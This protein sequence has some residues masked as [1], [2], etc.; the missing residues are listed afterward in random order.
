MA[1]IPSLRAL[2]RWFWFST[3]TLLVMLLNSS[4]SFFRAWTSWSF[5]FSVSFWLMFSSMRAFFSTIS[6]PYRYFLNLAHKGIWYISYRWIC[7]KSFQIRYRR[8]FVQPLS[9]ILV[10]HIYF[11]YMWYNIHGSLRSPVN[12]KK[13]FQEINSL[14][15]LSISCQRESNSWPQHYQCC[16]LPSELWQRVSATLYTILYA[17]TNCQY[18]FSKI[19]YF[20]YTIR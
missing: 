20:F 13:D 17:A 16:A 8:T 2:C 5:L 3:F 12:E 11:Q 10:L 19:L 9:L 4:F 7:N 15:S 18:H 6:N 14:E 1:P